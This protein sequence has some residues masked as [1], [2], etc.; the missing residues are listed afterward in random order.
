VGGG[1]KRGGVRERGVCVCK[2]SG[3][4]SKGGAR[5]E[6]REGPLSFS[7][8]PSVPLVAARPDVDTPL[9]KVVEGGDDAVGAHRAAVGPAACAVAAARTRRPADDAAAP[10]AR[11]RAAREAGSMQAL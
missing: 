2:E 6:G 10:R 7:P 11:R 5:S 1:L 9:E 4:R 3:T 8:L